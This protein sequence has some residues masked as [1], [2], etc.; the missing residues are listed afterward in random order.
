MTLVAAAACAKSPPVESPAPTGGATI[1]LRPDWRATVVAVRADSTVLTM[2]S[3]AK[4]RQTTAERVTFTL[5]TATDGAISIRLDSATRDGQPMHTRAIGAVW[6]VTAGDGAVDAVR[7][8]HGNDDAR[9]FT[10]LVRDLVPMIPAGG[11]HL[12]SR[13]VDSASGTVRVDVFNANEHSRS[14]WSI[15]MPVRR[16]THEAIPLH[17]DQSFEQFGSGSANGERLTMT[18]QGR[19]TGTWYLDADGTVTSAQ[20]RD[21]T[22]MMISVPA[23]RQVVPTIRVARTTLRYLRAAPPSA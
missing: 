1:S 18:S 17:V 4:Q 21:S 19:R 16:D 11:A 14:D 7:L 8:Q 22:A 2:P 6:S 15:D 13:W 20:L 23:S 10:A 5:A 12:A 3:G 9:V